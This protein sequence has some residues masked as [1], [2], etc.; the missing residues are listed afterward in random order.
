MSDS[1]VMFRFRLSY[2]FRVG[3]VWTGLTL[4]SLVSSV[5]VLQ[6]RGTLLLSKWIRQTASA[7]LCLAL[8]C[9][10]RQKVNR[11]C[12]SKFCENE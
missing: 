9:H 8:S 1:D 5:G 7:A 10:S 3:S 6:I 2:L 4:S 11:D 12:F